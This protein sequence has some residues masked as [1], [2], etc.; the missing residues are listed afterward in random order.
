MNVAK[1]YRFALMGL[2][3]AVLAAC[4]TKKTVPPTRS[5]GA[6]GL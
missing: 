5:R 4:G 1:F 6:F 2:A 3:A